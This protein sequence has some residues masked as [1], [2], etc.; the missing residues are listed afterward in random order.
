[1]HKTPFFLSKWYFDG[2]SDDGRAWI[3]YSAHLQWKGLTA[4][5]TG[6]LYLNAAGAAQ[7]ASRFRQGTGPQWSPDGQLRWQDAALGISGQWESRAPALEHRLHEGPEGYLDWHCHMPAARCRIRMAGEPD[8]EGWGYV[9]HLE[10]TVPPWQL[11]IDELRWGRFA[12]PEAPLVWIEWRGT[13]TRCWVFEG[14][15]RVE[16]AA[17]SDRTIQWPGQHRE[18]RLEQ[19]AIIEQKAKILEVM[20][21]L[22]R[23]LPGFQRFTPF[24]FLK[25]EE[26][27]WR[28]AGVLVE[29]GQERRRGWVIHECVNL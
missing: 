20:R 4:P 25:A 1:M 7:S 10:M 21:P 14:Q 26:W 19:S 18:L 29:N 23:L 15:N 11:G 13:P 6:F 27:K 22:V 28:S 12:N 5:Y 24:R 2:V 16:H 8:L 3:G 17:V 9:E